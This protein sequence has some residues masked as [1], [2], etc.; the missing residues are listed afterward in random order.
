MFK[1]LTLILATVVAGFLGAMAIAAP[2]Q[3]V[4]TCDFGRICWFDASNWQTDA[5]HPKYV[6][7][8]SGLPANTCFNMGTDPTGFNW[9]KR[10]DSVWWNDILY[11]DSYA[12]FY[13]GPNCTG[14]AITRAGAWSPVD[15]QMQSC[16]EPAA[17]WNGPCGP[18]DNLAYNRIMS[19]AFNV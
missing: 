9:S 15:Y 3:A 16:V 12:E 13:S 4:P 2:A 1:R 14:Y 8:P 17:E 5:T 10:A 7:N 18:P 11:P 6:V 19:W